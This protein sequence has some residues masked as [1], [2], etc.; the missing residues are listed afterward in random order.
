[1]PDPAAKSAAET[2]DE[3]LTQE[4]EPSPAERRD[5]LTFLITLHYGDNETV[6]GGVM[7]A[8]SGQV[9]I[10]V[11]HA[12]PAAPVR[13]SVRLRKGADS[14]AARGVAIAVNG[15]RVGEIAFDADAE[16]PSLVVPPG[17]LTEGTNTVTLSQPAGPISGLRPVKPAIDA[18]R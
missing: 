4:Q 6:A 18:S 15:V 14:E 5:R 7:T 3:V 10:A 9:T 17:L 11:R 12:A 16:L 2:D 8:G 13:I 1:M